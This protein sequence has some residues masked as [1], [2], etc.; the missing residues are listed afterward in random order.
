MDR[1]DPNQWDS[2]FVKGNA[3]FC[4]E[5]LRDT[6]KRVIDLLQQGVYDGC[7]KGVDRS[8]AKR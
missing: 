5:V 1:Y 8:C 3:T 4:M 2:N 7:R 6:N